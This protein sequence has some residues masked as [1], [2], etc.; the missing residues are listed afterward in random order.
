MRRSTVLA[1]PF[2]LCS[3]VKLPTNLSGTTTL[4]YFTLPTATNKTVLYETPGRRQM[5]SDRSRTPEGTGTPG[6]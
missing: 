3:L 1:F 5:P 2:S 4:A 6:S